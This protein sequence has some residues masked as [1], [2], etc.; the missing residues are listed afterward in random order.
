MS[1]E[2]STFDTSFG[3]KKLKTNSKYLPSFFAPRI[4][5]TDVI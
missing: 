3:C 4:I 2:Q 5:A 1:M